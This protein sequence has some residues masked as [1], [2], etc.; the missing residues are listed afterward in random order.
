MSRLRS[1]KARI[2]SLNGLPS[3]GFFQM[4]DVWV[5]CPIGSIDARLARA[6]KGNQRILEL[7]GAS[8]VPWRCWSALGATCFFARDT[9]ESEEQR[10]VSSMAIVP[11]VQIVGKGTRISSQAEAGILKR[12]QVEGCTVHI[13]NPRRK[14][15]LGSARLQKLVQ[16]SC[17]SR[18]LRSVSRLVVLVCHVEIAAEHVHHGSNC[19]V[20]STSVGGGTPRTVS[21]HSR[22]NPRATAE[23][24]PD[25]SGAHV[26]WAPRLRPGSGLPHTRFC[27]EGLVDRLEHGLA[28][29]F[30]ELVRRNLAQTLR[31]GR[32]QGGVSRPRG[33]GLQGRRECAFKR[34]ATHGDSSVET[35]L[36]PFGLP[37]SVPTDMPPADCPIMVTLPGSPPRTSTRSLSPTRGPQSGH[38]HPSLSHPSSGKW[39]KPKGPRR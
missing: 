7:G 8:V 2:S 4:H 21:P 6:R 33:S 20:P 29:E 25:S 22:D 24:P 30:D 5:R 27:A 38:G 16:R 12:H 23:R 9:C 36:W 34:G 32:R 19:V 26:P 31:G 18:P 1:W 35:T 39:R 3:G 10:N 11:E 15:S 14:A 13:T 17:V 28:N 37:T